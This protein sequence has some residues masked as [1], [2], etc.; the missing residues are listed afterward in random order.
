MI[1]TII[2]TLLKDKL[3]P[4]EIKSQI[5][6]LN[7]LLSGR[8]YQAFLDNDL[9]DSFE[10]ELIIKNFGIF[11]LAITIIPDE[12]IAKMPS[13]LK[14]RIQIYLDNIHNKFIKILDE[15]KKRLSNIPKKVEDMSREELL[16]YIESKWKNK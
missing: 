12:V 14:A 16:D 2:Q 7:N 6:D 10:K 8:E 1:N 3:S 13:E 11:L 5:A 4:E 9:S 15:N